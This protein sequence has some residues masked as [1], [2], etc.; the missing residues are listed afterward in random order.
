MT[1]RRGPGSSDPFCR[2]CIVMAPAE[3]IGL[4]DLWSEVPDRVDFHEWIR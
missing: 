1:G 2:D 3:S 4:E